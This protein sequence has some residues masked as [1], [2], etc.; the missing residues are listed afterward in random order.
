ML[1]V[2]ETVRSSL[3]TLSTP[4]RAPIMERSEADSWGVHGNAGWNPKWTYLS[5]RNESK[6][7]FFRA[8][9]HPDSGCAPVLPVSIA[10][11]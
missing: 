8:D 6:P 7:P 2:P 1:G 5:T 11:L 3:A 10:N 9:R 4:L